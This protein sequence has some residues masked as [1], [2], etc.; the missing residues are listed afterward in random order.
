MKAP[1]F[2]SLHAPTMNE[3]SAETRKATATTKRQ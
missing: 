1:P 2:T 3:A